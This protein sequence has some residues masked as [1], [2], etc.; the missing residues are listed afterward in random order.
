[1]YDRGHVSSGDDGKISLIVRHLSMVGSHPGIGHAWHPQLCPSILS[2]QHRLWNFPLLALRLH[3]AANSTKPR[4]FAFPGYEATG[5]I[6][7]R[8]LAF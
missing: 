5:D 1:M 3:G 4:R 8:S 2:M 6:R 7:R